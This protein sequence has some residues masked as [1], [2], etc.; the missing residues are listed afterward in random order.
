MARAFLLIRLTL[1][2]VGLAAASAASAVGGAGNG[3]QWVA[4]VSAVQE[5]TV[6]GMQ[7]RVMSVLES[8][9]SATLGIGFAVGGVIA[10]LVDPRA[11]FLVA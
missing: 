5:L 11:T 3:V 2:I 7:A 8:I 1:V 9:G 6:P 10:A 4:A